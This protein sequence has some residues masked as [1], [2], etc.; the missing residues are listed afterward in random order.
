MSEHRKQGWVESDTIKRRRENIRLVTTGMNIC[1]MPVGD[2]IERGTIAVYSHAPGYNPDAMMVQIV[3]GDK[4]A[5][6][7]S[8][9][10]PVHF[11]D[12]HRSAPELKRLLGFAR[13]GLISAVVFK[14]VQVFTFCPPHEMSQFL[15]GFRDAGVDI[16]FA[17]VSRV[18]ELVRYRG[19]A[20]IQDA[21]SDE[22]T[23][24]QRGIFG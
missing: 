11:A 17:D 15:I 5:R 12:W 16:H 21:T 18:N 14:D 7:L 19:D 6:D 22:A 9:V 1:M 20:P 23:A 24:I 4:C 8:G 10:D 2:V 13:R 3:T